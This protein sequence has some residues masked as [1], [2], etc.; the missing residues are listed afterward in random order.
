MTQLI[1]LALG[2]AFFPMLLAGAVVILTRPHP[3]R[4]LLAFWL[5]GLATSVVAGLLILS[6]FHDRSSVAGTTHHH[7]SPQAYFLTGFV[8][9]LVAL[10]IGTHRRREL[11]GRRP[12]RRPPKDPDATPWAERVLE[13][14][15]IPVAA[16]VGAVINLPGPFYLVALGITADHHLSPAGDLV[17][18]LGFNLVMFVLIEIPL[19]GYAVR[20]ERTSAVVTAMSAWLHRNGIRIATVL[21]TLVGVIAIAKGVAEL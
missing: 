15:T 12:G 8:A 18:V 16:G 6:A 19:V 10:L 21:V 5:G 2:A 4:L 7:V 14:G 1:P 20:P 13:R 11:L 3:A 17:A 9:L